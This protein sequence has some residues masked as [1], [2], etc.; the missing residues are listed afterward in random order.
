MSIA[1]IN[2]SQGMKSPIKEKLSSRDSY[3]NN[4]KKQITALE[5]EMEAITND[6]EKPAEE[7]KKEKQAAQE[8]LQNL[9]QELREYQI[10]K[11]QEEA[12][13]K[14]E[15]VKE[16]LA[17]ANE[18]E[19]TQDSDELPLYKGLRG[20]EAG[21]MIT[22]STTKEQL[23]GMVRVRKGLEGKQ[24]T[25][26]TEEE[27][28]DLQKKIDRVSRGIGQKVTSAKQTVSDLRQ[29]ITSDDKQSQPKTEKKQEE[30]FWADTK[31]S[32]SEK[33]AAANKTVLQNGKNRLFHEN[34]SFNIK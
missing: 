22:L 5:E 9:N 28:A 29:K 15:A 13:K 33:P 27:K 23:A 17:A 25:A 8:Q 18:A 3:E 14:R 30:I 24:R 1:G 16:A 7:K 2:S 21:I 12:E 32:S 4:I 10:R 20:E 34:V 19:Q 31:P 11:R 6:D 26:D